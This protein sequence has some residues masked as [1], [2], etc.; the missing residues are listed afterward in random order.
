M[1]QTVLE[2]AKFLEENSNVNAYHP[3][4]Y[5]KSMKKNFHRRK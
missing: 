2:K 4:S 3:R 1:I 5:K